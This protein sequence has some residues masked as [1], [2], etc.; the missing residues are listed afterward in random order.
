MTAP[1]AKSRGRLRWWLE[2]PTSPLL[3]ALTE[4]PDRI[5]EGPASVARGRVGRKRFFRVSSEGEGGALYVKVFT[6]PAG[7]PRLRSLARPS[8]ARRETRVAGEVRARGF[9]VAAPVA[10]GE[11]R[12]LRFLLRSF[13]VVPE[14]PGRD[15][16]ALLADPTTPP[17]ERRT[18]AIAFGSFARR[19][20]DAGIDQ[21]DFSPNNFLV[22]LA[23][24]FTLL[25]FERC[26]VDGPIG[27]RRW[28][29]LA[30]LH[31]HDL[32]VTRA[33]RLRLLDAYLGGESTREERREAWERIEA[34]FWDIRRRD[35]RRA[36]HAAFRVGRHV[37]RAGPA[38]FVKGREE[39]PVRRLALGRRDARRGW[40]TAHQLERL[41]L[42]ALRPVR[43]DLGHLELENPTPVKVDEERA[44]ARATRT[45][46]RYGSFVKNPEWSFT[47]AGALLVDPTSFKLEL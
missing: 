41:R 26:R 40:I 4:D 27:D 39:V 22:D 32:G 44:I 37:G 33:D 15:L 16:R 36:G 12:L 6:V 46:L 30:K 42:P 47:D 20:H 11:E 17:L 25:D 34:A 10:T 38:W 8:K 29:L 14:R 5:L 1:A 13:S 35:A 2:G 21:D 18:L 31:R 3:E 9:E 23:G 24:Q 7:W 19:L 43:L 45:L 28:K